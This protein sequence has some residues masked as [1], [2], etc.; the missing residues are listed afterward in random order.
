MGEEGGRNGENRVPGAQ[1]GELQKEEGVS[2]R[3]E[4]TEELHQPYMK[5]PHPPPASGVMAQLGPR[6]SPPS[7][8]PGQQRRR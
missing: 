3:L 5:A 7:R 2:A 6:Q 8:G 4:M 1:G